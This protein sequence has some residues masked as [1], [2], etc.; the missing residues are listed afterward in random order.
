[1]MS[2]MRLWPRYGRAKLR[3]SCVLA[4]ASGSRDER[5]SILV[6][7]MDGLCRRQCER[8]LL[9]LLDDER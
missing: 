1:M 7:M 6:I 5:A 9:T 4:A 2:S 3:W 8:A